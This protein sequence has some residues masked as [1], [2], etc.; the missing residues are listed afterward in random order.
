MNKIE[1]KD[2]YLV[3]GP[4]KQKAFR[5]LK[6]RKSKNEILKATNCTVAVKNAN[7]TIKEGEFFVI[8]GLSGQWQINFI[9]L[10][11]P[12]NQTHKRTSTD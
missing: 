2:L 12:V 8:M 11:K 4:E 9:A 7:L 6:E 3:F 10:H 5:M 1:I